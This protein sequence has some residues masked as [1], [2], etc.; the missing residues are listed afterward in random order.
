MSWLV[1]WLGALPD[2]LATTT[3]SG[4]PLPG[5]FDFDPSSSIAWKMVLIILATFILEDPTSIAV[6]LLIRAGSIAPVP[7]VVATMLGIFIGDVGLYLLG[8]FSGRALSSWNWLARRFSASRLERLRLWFDSRGWTAILASRFMPGTRVPLYIAI[9]AA[10]GSLPRFCLWTAIAVAVW[11]PFLVIGTALL[12]GTIL[13]PFQAVFGDG[14][15]AWIAVGLVL[16]VLLHFL[17]LTFTSEG[18][19]HLRVFSARITRWEFWSPWL[20]YGPM[21]PWFIYNYLRLGCMRTATAVDPCW[22]DGGAIGESKQRVLDLFPE[23]TVEPSFRHQPGSDLEAALARV[24]SADWGW[25]MILKPDEGQRG[26]GVHLLEDSAALRRQLS[27]T[28]IPVVL[29]RYHS[30]PGEVGLFWWR[31]PGEMTGRLFTICHK[32]FPMVEGNGRSTL[33]ELIVNDARLR[34]Q[35]KIFFKRFENQLDDV[36]PEGERV[37][38]TRAGNHA[39]GCLFVDGEHL[40][41]PQLEQ[42][43]DEVCSSVPGFFY[44]RL[45]VRY[46]DVDSLKLGEGLSV[47]E[48]NG[49]GSES[50]NM[51]DP[52]FSL[53]KAWSLVRIHW[54]VAMKIGKANRAK[55][56]TG[57]NEWEYL[58][59]WYRWR[60][61]GRSAELSD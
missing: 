22:P 3:G 4:L 17:S 37:Q 60:R 9:G 10:R 58:R 33:R 7:A 54:I 32:I 59:N 49:L 36:L 46:R 38:L 31:F 61:L 21:L 5:G 41:T 24:E 45:D 16:L 53:F 35:F 26:A 55:G 39:Q 8:R 51:Y 15:F 20:F 12:G 28:R 52:S 25:P 2:L 11:V 34:L 13:G 44:G 56:V 48:A 57:I 19:L 6:G 27:K 40:R 47:I 23:G 29:Q 18:R 30:G 1:P 50:T 42:W 43:L 14:V